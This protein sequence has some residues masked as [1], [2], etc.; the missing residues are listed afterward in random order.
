MLRIIVV[1]ASGS[2]SLATSLRKAGHD[3]SL[4]TNYH[5]ALLL[6]A[7]E[8]PDLLL[9]DLR[10]GAHNG[11][12]L[13]IRHRNTHPKMRSIVL[14]D[15]HDP[16]LA[17]EAN[18]CGAIYATNPENDRQLI[19]LVKAAFVENAARRWPRKR[20]LDPLVAQI[21]NRSVRVLDVSYGGVRFETNEADELSSAPM[22]IIF[23]NSGF[24]F[25]AQP[26]W[27]QPGPVGSRL[28]GAA[29]AGLTQVAQQEWRQFVDAVA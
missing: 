7:T 18:A 27:S 25:S 3:V 12:H 15:R 17:A 16:V 22:E 11:L 10:L 19:D 29:L 9:S 23:A 4:A 21:A 20:P 1:T 13:V 5:D 6:L 24:A 14:S 8:S 26:V 2:D 28:Y